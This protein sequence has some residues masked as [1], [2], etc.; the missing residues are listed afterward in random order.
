VVLQQALHL[1][2][3]ATALHQVGQAVVSSLL[4]D[5]ECSMSHQARVQ[6]CSMKAW[7]CMLQQGK[8]RAQAEWHA[9]G[10]TP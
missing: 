1:H 6:Q 7:K 10:C 9:L 5:Q 4:Q 8:G 3:G 2:L